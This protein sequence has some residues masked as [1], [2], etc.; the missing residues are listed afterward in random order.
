MTLISEMVSLKLLYF[1]ALD[2][3]L[4]DVWLSVRGL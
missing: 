2:D 1:S 4:V 3:E